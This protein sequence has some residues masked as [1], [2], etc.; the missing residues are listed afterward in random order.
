MLYVIMHVLYVAYVLISLKY[1][2]KTFWYSI[3]E[4]QN[5]KKGRYTGTGHCKFK[6]LVDLSD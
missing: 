4:I 2:H 3:F 1:D 5:L 6:L